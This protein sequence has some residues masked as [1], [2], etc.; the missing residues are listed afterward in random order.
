MVF[1]L[2]RPVMPYV[3][4][5]IH[6]D[7]ISKHLCVKKNIPGNDCQGRCYLQKQL[8]KNSEQNNDG[9]ND[10]SRIR[11]DRP[12]DHMPVNNN[13]PVPEIKDFALFMDISYPAIPGF[14]D[15]IFVPPKD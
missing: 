10:Q 11:F 1:Y 7:F 13:S 12:D 8:K 6:K 9:D 3:N 14:H 4:Y 15:K 5:A 2:V